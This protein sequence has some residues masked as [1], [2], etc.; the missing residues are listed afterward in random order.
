MVIFN[1]L[2]NISFPI[3]DPPSNF[4]SPIHSDVLKYQ[5]LN[6]VSTTV[7]YPGSFKPCLLN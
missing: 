7:S 5:K 6:Y 3:S 2:L 1:T 4:T